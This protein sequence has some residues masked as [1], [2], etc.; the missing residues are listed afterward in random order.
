LD[1]AD[2]VDGCILRAVVLRLLLPTSDVINHIK[3]KVRVRELIYFGR[4]KRVFF[5]WDKD[6][7]ML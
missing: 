2:T 4:K 3:T 7:P 5:I 6:R 1:P